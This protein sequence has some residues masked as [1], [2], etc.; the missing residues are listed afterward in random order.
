MTTFATICYRKFP[1]PEDFPGK[2]NVIRVFKKTLKKRFIWPLLKWP[3]ALLQK[4]KVNTFLIAVRQC[5]AKRHNKMMKSFYPE[6]VLSLIFVGIFQII[7]SAV[8]VVPLIHDGEGMHAVGHLNI[9]PQH[10]SV[11]FQCPRQN[12]YG[13]IAV[14]FNAGG[15]KNII[16]FADRVQQVIGAD[17]FLLAGP[18]QLED[19]FDGIPGVGFLG[20]GGALY[21]NGV[22]L[23][24]QFQIRA[25]QRKGSAA[26][27]DGNR[28][29]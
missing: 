14:G 15:P 12:K 29:T 17:D 3:A 9:H 1:F 18:V 20:D 2:G 13:G 7:E 6:I 8:G 26:P 11:S 16:P 25:V 21:G 24:R 4:N 28:Y 22:A 10:Q 23:Q 5:A 19:E 27:T